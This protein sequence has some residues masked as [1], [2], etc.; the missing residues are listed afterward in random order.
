MVPRPI[1]KRVAATVQ[2]STSGVPVER[3]ASASGI[4][5]F[6]RI[7]GA[8]FGTAILTSTWEHRAILQHAR[9]AESVNAFSPAATDYLRQLTQL[10]LQPQTALSEIDLVVTQ[11]SYLMATNA[12]LCLCGMLMVSLLLLVWWARPPF[13]I[14]GPG[15]H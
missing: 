7:L 8:S 9:L 11:Q 5:N 12:V 6:M 10:G 3:I 2:K 13:T 15:G 1:R 4:S 14:K